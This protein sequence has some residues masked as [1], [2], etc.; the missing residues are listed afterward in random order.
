MTRHEHRTLVDSQFGTVSAN[1]VAS[2]V[3]AQGPDL[4]QM[5]GIVSGHREARA[6]DLGSG[7]GHVSF[8][9]AP[10][11]REIVAYD[12]SS[13]MLAAVAKAAAE[14]GLSNIRT[15]QGMVERLSFPDASFD[16]VLSRYSAHHWHD[17]PAALREARRVL[18]A[19]GQA[20]FM[21]AVAPES[22]LVDT[23]FQ[24]IELMRDPSHVRDYSVAEWRTLMRQAG[25]EPGGV[26]L[27]R[28]RIEFA[29]WIQRMRTPEPLAVAIRTLMARAPEEVAAYLEIAG[30]GSFTMDTMTM[31][32]R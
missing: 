18:K 3:H 15:E 23:W 4:E 5:V 6:I 16:F 13:D 9:A 21:D 31:L 30:D 25:F 1:Y 27:R 20:V 14:R 19:G 32:A 10:H 29:S 24:S 28:L 2:A 26:T 22:P 7:G 11:V 12:L 8:H 17:V